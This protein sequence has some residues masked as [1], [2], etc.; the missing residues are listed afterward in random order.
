MPRVMGIVNVTPDSFSG[1]GLLGALPAAI[2]LGRRQRAEG[3]AIL[4]VGGE[5][6]RPGAT[7]VAAAEQLARVLPVIAALAAESSTIS[8]D[9]TSARVAD[10][11]LR[12]GARIVNDVSSFTD[13]D[14][15]RV[16]ADHGA[17]LV[18]TH[19]GWILRDSDGRD[20][21]D[22][23]IAALDRL[24]A[25][26]V[27]G[28]MAAERIVVDPG[29]GFGKTP[30][31]SLALLRCLPELRA[32]FPRQLLLVG[33]SRKGF[34]GQVLDLPVGERLEGTLA[35]VALAVAAGADIV[36]VHDVRAAS[37][38]A[39]MAQAIVSRRPGEAAP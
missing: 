7:P 34:I 23:V 16:A 12:A 39:R 4:D 10:A 36:R 6:T 24:V 19:N 25:L 22:R 20:V 1:D 37:R 17:W 14:I 5:S 2:A 8:I 27:R 28:G 30:A 26:A 15:V 13:P 33:P 9:T 11:A 18:A 32:R 29:L 3:A 31:E 38:V 35:C 21:V